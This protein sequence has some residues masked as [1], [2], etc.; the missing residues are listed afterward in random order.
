DQENFPLDLKYIYPDSAGAGVDVF[1][2]DSGIFLEHEEFQGRQGKTVVEKTFC[3]NPADENGHGTN[4]ASIVGGKTLGVASNA[5]IIGVKITGN[6]CPL[7]SQNIINGITYVM[8]QKANDPGRKI[9]LNLSATSTD[10]AVGEAA[11]KAVEAGI[12]FVVGAGNRNLDACGFFPGK[13]ETVVTVTASKITTNQQDWI[14]DWC[15]WGKCVTL[16]APGENVPVAGIGNPSEIK[17]ESGTSLSAPHVSGAI[18]LM[19]ANGDFTP[20]QSK[21]ELLRI[22]TKD[23]IQGLEYRP[24]ANVL[25]RVPSP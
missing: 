16:F 6:N 13:V 7:S 21:A 12:H 14:T 11:S 1:V 10:S 5:N 23:K 8:Q 15:N 22:A 18:A 9:V 2:V 19:L 4:V 25:L 20:E 17:L 3:N 24:T